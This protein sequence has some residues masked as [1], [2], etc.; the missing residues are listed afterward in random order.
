M[1]IWSKV[2][3]L[4]KQSKKLSLSHQLVKGI[5]G[6][7]ADAAYSGVGTAIGDAYT[8]GLVS[9]G[10]GIA[11]SQAAKEKAKKAAKAA[12]K[13]AIVGK[14]KSNLTKG[15][16]FAGSGMSTTGYMGAVGAGFQTAVGTA[17]SPAVLPAGVGGDGGSFGSNFDRVL[18]L[19]DQGVDAFAPQ[20][21]GAGAVPMFDDGGPIAGDPGPAPSSP[22][23]TPF[24]LVGVG[25]LALVLLLK[26]GK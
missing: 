2:T 6:K 8:G 23:L 11:Y 20:D 21:G 9:T 14:K 24:V 5:G 13:A 26:G 3:K 7:K 12:K 19:V 10:K 1:G 16:G 4:H 15:G 25:A 17:P 18:A 22:N